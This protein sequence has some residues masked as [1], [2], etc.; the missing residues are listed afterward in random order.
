MYNG[1]KFIFCKCG[2]I[3]PTTFF[4]F[5]FTYYRKDSTLFEIHVPNVTEKELIFHFDFVLERT[6]LSLTFVLIKSPG[7]I[8]AL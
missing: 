3:L 7:E 2:W 6:P 4:Y 1:K 8:D 5:D